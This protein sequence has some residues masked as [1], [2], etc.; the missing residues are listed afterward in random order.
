MIDIKSL[1]GIAINELYETYMEAYALLPV[2]V[3]KVGL[4]NMLHRRG[5][6][7]DLS[8]GVFKNDSLIS[9]VCIGVGNLN[10]EKTAF[11]II[12]GTTKKYNAQNRIKQLIKYAIPH[13]LNAKVDQ[14]VVEVISLNEKSIKLYESMGFEI[15]REFNYFIESISNIKKL[16]YKNKAIQVYEIDLSVKDELLSMCDYSPS[17]QN[18]FESIERAREKYLIIGAEMDK[19][20]VGYCVFEPGSGF[21]TQIAVH[22]QYRRKKIGTA[23]LK[24]AIELFDVKTIKLIN[25]DLRDKGLQAFLFQNKIKL[26]GKQYEMI[27]R[28]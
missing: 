6:R 24:K 23:L 17:Y 20:L 4:K 28:L 9:F 7:S 14:I 16:K 27:K 3:S 22:K 21:I 15:S 18:N 25:I 12:S 10:N 13:L 19:K 8:F 1:H 26:Q 5:Y 2:K 11:E